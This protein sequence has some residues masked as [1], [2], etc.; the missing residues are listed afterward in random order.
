MTICRPPWPPTPAPATWA[1]SASA[2]TSG[3]DRPTGSILF[4]EKMAGTVHLALGRSYPE[5]GGENDSALHWDLICDL[6]DGGRVERRWRNRS[7]SGGD[8]STTCAARRSSPPSGPPRASPSARADDRGG[9]GR[10]PPELLPRRPR[11]PRRERAPGTRGGR[12]GRAPGGHPPGPARPQAP[13]RGPARRDRRAQAGRAACAPLRRRHRGRRAPDVGELEGPLR[14]GRAPRRHLPGRRGHPPARQRGPRRR[15]GHRCGDRRHRGH[16]SGAEP[17]RLDAGSRRRPRGRPGDAALRRVDRGRPDRAILR[18]HGAGHQEGP[19][20]HPSA[21]DRQDR[22]APGGG[23]GRRDHLRRRLC[24]GGPRRSRHRAADRDRPDRAKAA[25]AHGRPAGPPRHHRHPDARVD[26]QLLA[27]H[28]GRGGRRGQRHPRRHRRGHALGR[29][30]DRQLPG[31]GGGDDGPRGRADRA[32]PAHR[33][34][35][36]GARPPRRPRPCLH[37]RLQCLRGRPRPAPGRARRADPVRALG[38]AHLRPPAPGADL[39][40]FAGQGDGAPLRTHVGRAGRP[41]CAAT[42]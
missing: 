30:G 42:R 40:P 41:R 26:G 13:H 11:L 9:H 28:P 38:P 19:P 17:P 18:A 21:P 33:D 12:P 25:A 8:N 10:R 4:D 31:P 22:E 35:E 27:A 23:R 3:I 6:R 7:I 1:S 14:G 5:T 34:L 29:D 24:D 32:G 15:G 37:D 16:T 39:R 20:P 36:R 2:P